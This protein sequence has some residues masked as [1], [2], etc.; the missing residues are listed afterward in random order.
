[1][2]Q[3]LIDRVK[4]A[5]NSLPSTLREDLIKADQPIVRPLIR[6]LP[7]LSSYVVTSDVIEI[8]GNI[9]GDDA[10]RALSTLLED[11][12]PGN[13][14]KRLISQSCIKGLGNI[15]NEESIQAISK[16][17]TFHDNELRYMAADTLGKIALHKPEL[18]GKV[19]N[20][21]RLAVINE[22]FEKPGKLMEDIL[23]K[24]GEKVQ[25][26][27][28]WTNKSNK[29]LVIEPSENRMT[30]PPAIRPL[31]PSEAKQNPDIK[32]VQQPE[33]YNQPIKTEGSVPT[34]QINP[35]YQGF[36][37]N[38][39]SFLTD[40]QQKEIL[41]K[42][43]K[44]PDENEKFKIISEL[45]NSGNTQVI[46][47]LLTV[48]K[49]TDCR[50]VRHAAVDAIL[51]IAPNDLKLRFLMLEYI[52]DK[53]VIGQDEAKLALAN[54]LR[55]AQIGLKRGGVSNKPIGSFLFVGPTGVGKTEL[56]KALAEALYGS[57][58]Q[59]IRLDMSEYTDISD[60]N[61]LIGSPPGYAGCDEGGRLTQAVINKPQSV[62]LFD[63]IEKAHVELFNLFLQMMDDGRLTDSKG[64]T[65]S[66][67][68]TIIIMTSNVG[69]DN[70]LEC[71]NLK[72][73]VEEIKELVKEVLKTKFKPEFLNRLNEYV[74]FKPL[75]AHELLQVLELKLKP[76]AN[77]LQ[78]KYQLV[79]EVSDNAKNFI[80]EN[81]IK[82]EF[83]FSPRELNRIIDDE[84]VQPLSE[85][86]LD[87]EIA[88]S[89]KG[90][91]VI[92]R[93]GKVVIDL[94]DSKLLIDIKHQSKEEV[95]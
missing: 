95:I 23:E 34:P 21:L 3:H 41:E 84:I 4:Y 22:T 59:L 49:S 89:Y 14:P 90:K 37:S 50:K 61:K 27:D 48:I 57:E 16:A 5:K 39:Y 6:L 29:P 80:I 82:Q 32:A 62:I 68:D 9:G 12:P 86:L 78:E 10:L 70:I 13:L 69:S 47:E 85:K 15:A 44:S 72:M 87:M 56:A 11:S 67:K 25:R 52:L 79:F 71:I 7:A 17:L 64:I 28:F 33:Q 51:K 91:Y 93:G 35:A 94:V 19:S 53:R 81:T 60:K 77:S 31:F 88:E 2:T 36:S 55:V 63:E 54:S 75:T 46:D 74:I 76:T 18:K 92:P 58:L 66:F 20:T 43:L 1:M 26:K 30:P 73:D 24:M 65:V 42:L 8:L 40:E 83:G 38:E 45:G